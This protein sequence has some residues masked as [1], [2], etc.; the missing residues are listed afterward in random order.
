MSDLFDRIEESKDKFETHIEMTMIE[1]YNEQIRDLL[2]D[3]FPVCPT[4]GLKLLENEKER[5]TIADVSMRQPKSVDEVM[6]LV[7]LGNERRSTSSTHANNQSSRS[8]AVLQISVTRSS[9][10]AD[11]D[12]E[13]ERVLTDTSQATL[14][15]VDLAGSERASATRNMGARMKE[16]AKI[17]QS[18]L[19]LSSCISALCGAQ[20]SGARPH[21]PYRNSKLTRLLKFSLGGNCRTVMIVCVSPSSR[22]MEDTSNTLTWANKAKDVKMRVSR[23]VGGREVSARQYL[24]KITQQGIAI[25]L[26]EKELEKLQAEKD[27]YKLSKLVDGQKKVS[28]AMRMVTGK[29]DEGL[30]GIKEGAEQRARWDVAELGATAL[31]VRRNQ[32]DEDSNIVDSGVEKAYCDHLIGLHRK[33]YA[34]NRSVQFKVRREAELAS[35][36]DTS[37]KQ[38]EFKSFPDMDEVNIQN[39]RLQVELQRMRVALAVAESREASY[40]A[41][42]ACGQETLAQLASIFARVHA[43]GKQRDAG[44]DQMIVSGTVTPSNV[45][46]IMLPI[47]DGM[48]LCHDEVAEAFAAFTRTD[49]I[50]SQPMRPPTDLTSPIA[51]TAVLPAAVSSPSP[52]KSPA[53]KRIMQATGKKGGYVVGAPPSPRAKPAVKAL[54]A[55]AGKVFRF[56]DEAGEGELQTVRTFR[57]RSSQSSSFDLSL[58]EPDDNSAD[59]EEMQDDVA[60]LPSMRGGLRI[61]SLPMPSIPAP[62]KVGGATTPP[63]PILSASTTDVPTVPAPAPAPEDIANMPEWKKNRILLGK[64]G[65]TPSSPSKN[66]NPQSAPKAA[67]AGLGNPSR[68]ARPSLGELRQIPP[69]PRSSLFNSTLGKSTSPVKPAS[70][71]SAPVAGARRLSVSRRDRNKLHSGAVPYKRKPSLIPSPAAS[72][73]SSP[74]NPSGGA[75]DTSSLGSS[76][77]NRTLGR[78]VRMRSS[79]MD[80]GNTSVGNTSLGNTSLE[81]LP[82]GMKRL[83]HSTSTNQLPGGGSL[84]PRPSISQLNAAT[85]A[86]AAGGSGR[87]AWR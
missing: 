50:P 86:A 40:R 55:T 33:A 48:E 87:P 12:M 63:L 29:V 17:N 11:V 74:R 26:L 25:R 76:T 4:G 27:I 41:A 69:R 16:G 20:K 49:A 19:A 8:H 28:E 83:R 45:Q 51:P 71:A 37:L 64:T 38:T 62:F 75:M 43:L 21:V 53:V 15:I 32:I 7:M 47:Q 82:S 77:T 39:L 65:T 60:P 73:N 57:P 3:N 61:V 13:G 22:D 46:Q 31:E 10:V 34:N 72:P 24:E 36:I 66:T 52:K 6:D 1:L 59:W 80:P 84:R 9:K 42:A 70:P 56:A 81:M 54:R 85:A 78:P 44:V 14:S 58:A 67:L 23:N 2:S 30:P 5:V 18:L 68:P 79:T 35:G